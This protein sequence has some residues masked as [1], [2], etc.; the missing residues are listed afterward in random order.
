[1]HGFKGQMEEQNWMDTILFS[2]CDFMPHLVVFKKELV[3]NGHVR[4]AFLYFSF[5]GKCGK[6]FFLNLK[7]LS[8]QLFLKSGGFSWS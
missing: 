2:C 7:H 3:N 1:M 4:N 8:T 5:D 6:I